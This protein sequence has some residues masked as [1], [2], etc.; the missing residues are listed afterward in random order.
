M[1]R[2]APIQPMTATLGSAVPHEDGWGFEVKWDGIRA[3]TFVE[4][5]E[6]FIQ[7]RNLLDVTSQYPEVCEIGKALP[8]RSVVLDG[9][10]VAPDEHG[11]PQFSRLQQRMHQTS[12]SVINEGMKK[13]PVS[14]MAFDILSLDGERTMALPYTER[15]AL[16]ESLDLHGKWWQTPGYHV[17]DGE[18]LLA[19]SKAQ[20]LEGIVAKRLDSTYEPG[21]R[22]RAWLKIKNKDRQ[23]FVIG[24]WSP[25]SGN[26]AGHFGAL[27]IGYYEGDHLI[28]A[29]HVGTGFT[30]QTLDDLLRRLEALRRDTSPFESTPRIPGAVWVEPQ[31]VGEVEF[32]EWTGDGVLRHPAFKGLR[33]DKDPHDV[34]REIPAEGEAR[35]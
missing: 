7:S 15:R 26:R 31:L 27:L 24:G 21:K 16:L 3:I 9:E 28:Y 5:G 29:G 30:R 14:Y 23:E 35:E 10:I 8:D 34:V 4:D 19:A 6:V 20:K 17:G 2:P 32:T 25:G 11:R 33:E 22:T 13:F 1:K 12:S 18:T